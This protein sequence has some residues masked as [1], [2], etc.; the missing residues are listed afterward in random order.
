MR[1]DRSPRAAAA[2]WIR[3]ALLLLVPAWI[4][5]TAGAEA[6]ELPSDVCEMRGSWLD[7]KTG[8]VLAP[9]RLMK[10]L[11]ERRSVLLGET[12]T[13]TEHHRWQLH[14]LA[15]L[16]A[17]KSNLVVGFEM[18]PRSV[19][20]VLDSW[21]AGELSEAAFLEASNWAEVWGYD[22]DFY[23]PLFHFARQ[24]RLPMVGLNVDRQ[25]VSR[26]A[27][28]GWSAIPEEER[29]GVSDPA[30]AAEAYRRRLV[31]VYLTKQILQEPG[32]NPHEAPPEEKADRAPDRSEILMSEAFGRFVEAQL[33]WDRAMAQA[34]AQAH[35][36]HPS[37]IVVGIMGRGHLEHG[38]GVPHQ[39]AD[40][41]EK[42][43]AVLLPV[44]R[45]APCTEL[46][47]EVADAVFLVEASE[48][49]A[50]APP[51]AR[52]GITIKQTEDGV[53][54]LEVEQGSVA[55]ATDL[56][57]GDVIV[58]AAGTPTLRAVALIEIVQRQAPGTWLPLEV[59][60]DEEI[61]QLVAK[62]PPR[63]D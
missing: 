14:T 11:A 13:E 33:T 52:L 24:N 57:P 46:E 7:P 20:P 10:A 59:K 23:L 36:A 58:A 62:F 3:L 15:G 45:G 43:V 41:G 37:A 28:E 48:R 4:V 6:H 12:H 34:L 44:E 55:E 49:E 35:A 25:L 30:P 22:A 1:H 27:H 29:E 8:E 32:G 60:R 16:H 26:V 31:D 5:P 50:A 21:I 61:I 42:Q 18:F 38:H 51:R 9:D 19:Q 54:V 2:G 40:L 53:R 63:F 39:L 56:R 17:H 47:P